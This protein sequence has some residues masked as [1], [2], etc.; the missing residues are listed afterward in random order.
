[1]RGFWDEDEDEDL[2]RGGRRGR[3][4]GDRPR[5]LAQP[6][7]RHSIVTHYN[8]VTQVGA[9]HGCTAR[10]L[11]VSRTVW[12]ILEAFL[13]TSGTPRGIIQKL[14]RRRHPG[15]LTRTGS[16]HAKSW[17]VVKRCQIPVCNVQSWGVPAPSTP[18]TGRPFDGQ[19]LPSIIQVSSG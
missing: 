19:Q 3:R 10:L 2:G 15:V 18:H 9:R 11:T 13:S 1:M 5:G 12:A 7:M 14:T 16:T 6:K 8:A 4:R 17:L